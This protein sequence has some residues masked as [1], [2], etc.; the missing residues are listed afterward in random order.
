M[1]APAETFSCP[2]GSF[3][4][5]AHNPGPPASSRKR[6]RLHHLQ[7]KARRTESR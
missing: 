2:G 1:I 6:G 4:P 7:A 3:L 5:L